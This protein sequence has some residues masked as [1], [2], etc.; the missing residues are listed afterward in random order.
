MKILVRTQPIEIYLVTALDA[1][2]A[3]LNADLPADDSPLFVTSDNGMDG[4]SWNDIQQ[5]EHEWNLGPGNEENIK[6]GSTQH[7]IPQ[8]VTS[9]R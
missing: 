3:R 4:L 2:Q 1:V 5:F 9:P 8:W 7:F 6:S